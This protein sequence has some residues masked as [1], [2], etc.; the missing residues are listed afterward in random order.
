MATYK[1][2]L[3][4]WSFF[5]NFYYR[6]KILESDILSIMPTSLSYSL[7]LNFNI[8]MRKMGTEYL[9]WDAV[10]RMEQDVIC[11]KNGGDSGGIL[12]NALLCVVDES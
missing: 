3:R 8:R 5:L 1:N 12:A 4:F 2:D 10:C 6:K 9:T 7:S 11:R